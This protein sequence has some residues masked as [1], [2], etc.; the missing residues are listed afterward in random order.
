MELVAADNRHLSQFKEY[1]YACLDAGIERY[2]PAL[3]NPRLYLQRIVEQAE[4]RALPKEWLPTRTYFCFLS[5]SIVGSLR[6]RIGQ[7]SRA[8][9]DL[10][11]IGYETL[12]RA[13]NNGVA[14]FMLSTLQASLT[15]SP[16]YVTCDEENIAS[17]KVIESCATQFVERVYSLSEQCYVL[18]YQLIHI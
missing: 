8:M 11:H 6:L 18:R 7:N 2:E 17:K 13:R 4:G 1:V 9:N 10:G 3:E 12:P 16:I 5:G 14:K 15:T